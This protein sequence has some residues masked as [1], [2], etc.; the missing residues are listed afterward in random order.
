MRPRTSVPLS[1]RRYFVIHY[2]GAGTP[3]SEVGAYAKWIERIHVDQNGW[4]GVGY[5]YF[6]SHGK[7]AEGCGRDIVGS[8]SPPR[9]YDGIGVNIWTSN[10]VPLDEDLVLARQ[11]YDDLNRAKGGEPLIKSY[12]G[13]DYPTECPG[14]IL[15]NWVNSG[16]PSPAATAVPEKDWFDMA[17]ADELRKIVQEVV[18]EEIRKGTPRAEM[19]SHASLD[20]GV[21][22]ES[23]ASA[24]RRTQTI[25]R[26]NREKIN[27][28]RGTLNGFIKELKKTSIGKEI[29]LE[30]IAQAAR[31]GAAQGA[32][33]VKAEDIAAKL[34]IGVKE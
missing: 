11:L 2:P 30:A 3:P 28:V 9:N 14:P 4:S 27:D 34:E 24:V 17:T 29:D 22:E 13:K 7:I 6:I 21:I 15:R 31:E 20:G 5:N 26:Q 33:D 25:G 19:K 23:M 8:H 32:S 10:G 18:R 12:H 16:M 1:T